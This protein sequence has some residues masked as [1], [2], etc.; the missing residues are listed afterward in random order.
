MDATELRS[1]MAVRAAVALNGLF[2]I[3]N[4]LFML[5]APM[6]WYY[7]VPGV[8]DTGAFNQ[9]FVRDIGIIQ[10]FLGAAFVIGLLRPALRLDLWAAAT[11]WLIAHAMFHVW[12]VAV[13]ICGPS[14]LVRDFPAVSLPALIGIAVTTWA[15]GSSPRPRRE[16]LHAA[17]AAQELRNSR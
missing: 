2:L 11:A 13:G 15:W 3:G 7:F 5:V 6:T 16:D 1:P 4:G 9:H 8:T 12:E 10:A 14:T 17:L